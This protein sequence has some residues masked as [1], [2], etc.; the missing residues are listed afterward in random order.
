MKVLARAAVVI[1]IAAI[2]YW[3]LGP[4]ELRPHWMEANAERFTAYLVLGGAVSVAF[5]RSPGLIAAVVVP[6]P[7]CLE[8]LQLVDPSRHAR[9]L[10]ALV[11]IAGGLVGVLLANLA[12]AG[13]GRRS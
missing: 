1:L 3:T 4:I 10:D 11:K 9:P 13:L 12:V 2:A 7:V 5:P 8:L 6:L